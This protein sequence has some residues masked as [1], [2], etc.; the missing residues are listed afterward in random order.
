MLLAGQADLE[1]SIAFVAM[2]PC[3]ECAKMVIAVSYIEIIH[4]TYYSETYVKQGP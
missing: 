3:R 2:F 1:G 4:T